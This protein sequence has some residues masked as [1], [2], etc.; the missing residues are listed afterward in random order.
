MRK[1]FLAIAVAYCLAPL[2]VL[3]ADRVAHVLEANQAATAGNQ[4]QAKAGLELRYAYS[5]QGLTGQVVSIQDIQHGRFVDRSD[6]GPT[7]TANGFDGKVAWELEP[8]GTAKPQDG[9]DVRQLAINEAYRLQNLWW[10]AD[11]GGA[12]IKDAGHKRDDGKDYDV[13]TVAPKDGKPFDAW[14]DSATHLLVRTVE[15]NTTLTLSTY[16]A[17]FAAT[18]GVQLAHLVVVDDGSGEANRQTM[19]LTSATFSHGADDARFAL[20]KT[21]LH[22]FELAAGATQTTVPFLLANNHVYVKASFN[23]SKPLNVIVDTGG[24]DILMP[25]SATALGIKVEG[26]QTSTGAGNAVAQSGLARVQSIRVGG[27]TLKDQPITVLKF[28]NAAEGLDEQGMIGYEFFARF[29]TRFDYGRHE[30]T[31]IDKR[32]FDPRDAGTPV[33]FRFYHQFPEVLGSYDGIPGRFGIDTG[34][35][36]VLSLSRPF[37]ERNRLRDVEKN[38][39]EAITGW[40]VGGASRGYV[41]R[42]QDLKLGD[43]TVKSPLTEFSLDKGGAGGSEAFPNNVGSG[44]L[45]RFVVT[46]DYDRQLM[47]LKPIP[48]KIDDLDT[49]DRSGMWLNVGDKGFGVV[50]VGTGTPAAKA[51]LAAGDTIVAVD[52]DAASSIRLFDLR[53]RL[54]NDAPGTEVAL[55]VERDG[56]PRKVT[57]VLRDL[58]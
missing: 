58:I 54:R 16:Y 32:H 26:A 34:A 47:Y 39:A 40:G 29:I 37:A 22:D 53:R 3:A 49:F 19:K 5:G 42:G 43:V 23:G 50:S 8:S 12:T 28:S 57:V 48:G 31:F 27:A 4:W 20:P 38:G 10:R 9:G 13:L 21:D 18:D 41:Y 52:G 15:V 14:F 7:R 35:R 1:T 45:K 36:T 24:H 17:D 33:P 56:K 2:G 6:I 51:G 46:L 25:D 55:T 44:L 11:R 30:L